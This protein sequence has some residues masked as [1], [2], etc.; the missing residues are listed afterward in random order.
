MINNVT[1][2]YHGMII[3]TGYLQRLFVAETIYRRLNEP[4]N[5]E[6][7]D[8]I[9][10]LMDEAY[11][12]IPVY[13]QTGSL[14]MA[15]KIEL[16]FILQKTEELMSSY[17]KQMPLSYNQKLAIVGSSLYAD[18]HVNAG[19]VRLGEIFQIDV[20]ED[21]KQRLEFYE[22]RTEL[23]DYIVYVLHHND[24]PNVQATQQIDPW[25]N[26]IMKNKS[27]ID[28][29]IKKIRNLIGFD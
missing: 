12:I 25:F 2:Q 10:A 26:G 16:K 22:E 11:T 20:G 3:L 21:Y 5:Q 6:R 29:D 17:F 24:Q 15:Q 4:Y 28:D 7:F 19:I 23:I 1:A 14:T 8:Q 13:E 27:L 18:Q 9:K